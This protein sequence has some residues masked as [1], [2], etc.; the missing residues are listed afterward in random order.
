MGS[1]EGRQLGSLVGIEDG[2]AVLSNNVYFTYKKYPSLGQKFIS[3]VAVV[4][5][6]S[7]PISLIKDVTSTPSSHV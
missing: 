7:S 2:D 3:F 6:V 5:I 1:A 4:V